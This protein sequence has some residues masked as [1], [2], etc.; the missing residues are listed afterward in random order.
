MANRQRESAFHIYESP[1]ECARDV[2]PSRMESSREC[3]RDPSPSL[4]EEGHR[5]GRGYRL[6]TGSVHD[7]TS[8][9]DSISSYSSLNSAGALDRSMG[10]DLSWPR[11]SPGISHEVIGERSTSDP[12]QI[13]AVERQTHQEA[14]KND[15]WCV[16]CGEFQI[17]EYILRKHMKKRHL[18][19]KERKGTRSK[20]SLRQRMTSFFGRLFVHGQKNDKKEDDNERKETDISDVE[21]EMSEQADQHAFIEQVMKTSVDEALVQC[22]QYPSPDGK[23]RAQRQKVQ[24]SKEEVR[25]Q[26]AALPVKRPGTPVVAQRRAPAQ[27]EDARRELDELVS[28]TAP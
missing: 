15:F 22:S 23:L 20:Q 26:A 11:F 10:Y 13:P 27:L 8:E 6:D 21:A 3:K 17:N 14:P 19:K 16:V 2:S 7:S 4:G 24:P 25:G 5:W 18:K 28:S 1:Q 12:Q 9:T